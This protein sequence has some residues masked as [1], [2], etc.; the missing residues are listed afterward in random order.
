MTQLIQQLMDQYGYYVLGIA[1]MLE[2]LALP[3]PGEVLMTYTGLMIF[4]GHLNW[5]LSI[6]TAGFGASL[7]MTLSYWIGFKLGTP[8]FEKYGAKIHLG[9]DKL[10]KTSEWFERYGNKLLLIAY[11]IP[12]IRHF[13]GYFSGVTRMPFRTYMLFAYTGAFL[14][15]GTFI[16]LGK[17]LGPK[18]EQFHHTITKYLIIAGMIAVLLF[19]AVYMFRRYKAQMV[20]ITLAGL[21]KGV[22]TF[23]SLGKVKLLV[24]IA[25]GVFLILFSVMAGLI[26]DFLAGEFADFDAVTT[27]IVKAVFDETW[28]GWMNRFMD[29]ASLPVLFTIVGLTVVWVL[30]KGRDRLLEVSFLL[31]V[32]IGGELWDEGLRKLFHRTG[33]TSLMNTFPSEQTL[34]TIIF[35]GFAMYLFVRHVRIAWI[36]TGALLLVL[37]VS[38]LVGISR[39]Y[40]DI[41]Y[42]SD[43]A[44]GYVFGGVWL[45]LNIVLLELFRLFK[46]NKSNLFPEDK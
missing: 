29:L 34:I 33:P 39:I 1:L 37:A 14:W 23:H 20:T 45:S 27:F 21:N 43:V 10:R 26:Q 5:G 38:F 13:T 36:R 32:L 31:F 11:Y 19:V 2:L 3:L 18:W 46:N 42:P 30:I 22:Q 41:Q 17:V 15:T 12:G 28:T 24:V 9:P 4:Q 40:F 35:L 44:A 8:F 25:F 7:G 16:S 6:L